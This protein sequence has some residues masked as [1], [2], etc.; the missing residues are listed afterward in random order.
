MNNIGIGAT[1]R[2][3]VVMRSYRCIVGAVGAPPVIV[4]VLLARPHPTSPFIGVGFF[5]LLLALAR[6]GCLVYVGWVVYRVKYFIGVEWLAVCLQLLLNALLRMGFLARIVPTHYPPSFDTALA[7]SLYETNYLATCC[8]LH[9]RCLV[10]LQPRSWQCHPRCHNQP[11]PSVLPN[12]L[13]IPAP[14]LATSRNAPARPAPKPGPG[15]I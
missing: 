4:V 14:R 6:F 12:R 7:L 10:L 1:G 13:R 9:Y 11:I 15:R 5:M 3:S 2:R 8:G